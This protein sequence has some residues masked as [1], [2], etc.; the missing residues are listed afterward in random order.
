MR[1]LL[2]VGVLVGAF[3]GAPLP[4]LGQD[5]RSHITVS[6]AAAPIQDVLFT[7]AEFADRSIVAGPGIEGLV[8]AEIRDQPWEVAFDVL[9]E[10]HGLVA[11]ELES[12]IIRVDGARNLFERETVLPLETRAFRAS[13]GK[14]PNCWTRS[15]R[16]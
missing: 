15:R 12:G 10:A 3:T 2:G 8:S 13:Y 7:F 5:A 14:R 6:F 1:R 11:R 9:L 4:L 16:C